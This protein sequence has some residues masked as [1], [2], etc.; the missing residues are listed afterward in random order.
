MVISSKLPRRK[1]CVDLIDPYN[2][3]KAVFTEST[4]S[5]GLYNSHKSN[6][7]LEFSRNLEI[8]LRPNKITHK[9]KF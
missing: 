9:F 3:V 6:D 4:S 5:E 7:C 1:I 8:T 2:T